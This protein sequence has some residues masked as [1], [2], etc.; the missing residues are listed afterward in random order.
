MESAWLNGVRRMAQPTKQPAEALA[1]RHGAQPHQMSE[2]AELTK[3]KRLGIAA[4][5]LGVVTAIGG[6]FIAHFTGLSKFSNVT[7]AVIL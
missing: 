4:V 1:R 3:Y 7:G 6:V 2:T 5:V